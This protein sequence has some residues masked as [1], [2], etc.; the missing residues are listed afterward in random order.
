MSP[1]FGAG[2]FGWTLSCKQAQGQGLL[3]DL[4]KITFDLCADPIIRA[5][6]AFPNTEGTNTFPFRLREIKFV[7]LGRYREGQLTLQ[8]EFKEQLFGSADFSLP[9][10][11]IRNGKFIETYSLAQLCLGETFFFAPFL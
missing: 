6:E 2:V 10:L 11:D 3:W 7:E 8:E 1:F 4:S 5:A 9:V